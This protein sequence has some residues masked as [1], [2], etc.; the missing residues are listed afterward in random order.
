ME[1]S[2][3]DQGIQ[4]FEARVGDYN[5]EID[6]PDYNKIPYDDLIGCTAFVISGVYNGR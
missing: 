3:C 1:L 2:N 5:R 4:R 6:A